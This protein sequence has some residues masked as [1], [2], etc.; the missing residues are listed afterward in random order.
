MVALF[1]GTSAENTCQ[2]VCFGYMIPGVRQVQAFSAY[3]LSVEREDGS[4]Q[5]W[6]LYGYLHT[7]INLDG[8]RVT[9]FEGHFYTSTRKGTIHFE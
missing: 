3:I 8:Q 4:G 1:F 9:R 5:S 2:P 6:N 7:P